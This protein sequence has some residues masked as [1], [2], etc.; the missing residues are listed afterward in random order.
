MTIPVTPPKWAARGG[1]AAAAQG[2]NE[3]FDLARV[4]PPRQ[5]VATRFKNGC[6][7]F[8]NV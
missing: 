2:A 8:K 3:R 4:V 7:Y 6:V 5:G 1:G